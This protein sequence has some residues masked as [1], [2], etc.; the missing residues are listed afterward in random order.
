MIP[1]GVSENLPTSH[2]KN[3]GCPA[4]N[5]FTIAC[6][7]LS[8]SVFT[9]APILRQ[10]RVRVILDFHCQVMKQKPTEHRS[11]SPNVAKS[12][13][14]IQLSI[15]VSGIVDERERL[16]GLETAEPE[17]VH[18]L[19]RIK[20]NGQLDHSPSTCQPQL[21]GRNPSEFPPSARAFRPYRSNRK[22]I[23]HWLKAVH[24]APLRS[25]CTLLSSTLLS[26]I[27]ERRQFPP[28]RVMKKHGEKT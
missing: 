25:Q 3:T 4:F 18:Q 21:C 10:S 28:Q 17:W 27:A 8:I 20:N 5:I 24:Q 11:A 13:D 6:F 22:R 15:L 7:R 9:S 14:G 19:V 23:S 12:V 2:P 16:C 26:W 1:A